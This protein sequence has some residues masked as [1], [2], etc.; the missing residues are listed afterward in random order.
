MQAKYSKKSKNFLKKTTIGVLYPKIP[1]ARK[2]GFA[3]PYPPF[4]S[5]PS[6]RSR[7]AIET[8]FEIDR[9]EKSDRFLSF[10]SIESKNRIEFY[11]KNRSDRNIESIFVTLIDRIAI[12][13]FDTDIS[14]RFASIR[15]SIY[16]IVISDLD[17]STENW[18]KKIFW[19]K[20][21]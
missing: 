3:H 9:I 11:C 2:F 21:F 17:L 5:K 10:K 13:R 1:F 7:A 4:L 15:Y 16:R 14:S 8:S 18:S 12:F 19:F 6:V 20:C